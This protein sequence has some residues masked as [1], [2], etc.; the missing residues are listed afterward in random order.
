[1]RLNKLGAIKMKIENELNAKMS[2]YPI[3]V[4]LGRVDSRPIYLHRPSFDC[5]WYWGFGY[6]GNKDCHYHLDGLN[7]NKNLYDALIEHFGDTL[8]IDKDKL[9]SFCEIVKTIYSL[10]ESAEVLGRGGSHYT[11]NPCAEIIKKPDMVLE[12]N[13]VMIPELINEMYKTL[14]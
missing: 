7:V 6:L 10:K 5:G 2:D 13:S 4:L 1:L 9:W 12:I 8:K 3:K 14:E 11:K